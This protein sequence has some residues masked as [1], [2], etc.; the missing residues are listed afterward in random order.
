MPADNSQML[1][2]V[3][4]CYNPAGNIY[5]D[6]V[7]AFN[8]ISRVYPNTELI[9]VNDGSSKNFDE[10][11]AG[12][13][14]E[15]IAN[16]KIISYPLN[17]GKGFALREGVKKAAGNWIIYTDV[18]FPYTT[19]SFFKILGTLTTGN[20]DIAVGV[21]PDE[22]YRHLPK[23]RVRISK[24][25][26]FLIRKFLNIPTDDTQCGLKG[27]NARGKAV[28]LQT[29]IE[30]YLFDLEFIF[31]ASRQKLAVQTVEVNLRPE[32]ILSP[33]RWNILIQEFGN[34]LKI[35]AQSFF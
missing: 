15:G 24:F 17:R 11:Q 2:V 35:F 12:H 31:L 27:F 32:V 28:F 29:S 16:I 6:T 4:P 22:Y 23:S 10:T 14:F 3:L 30:R 5:A 26:R 1:S 18:D 7:A 9:L 34:F 33:M 21:R 8:R 19:D 20:C 13:Y 25:L